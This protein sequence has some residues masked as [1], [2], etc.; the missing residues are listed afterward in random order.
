MKNDFAMRQLALNGGEPAVSFEQPHEIWPPP[1]TREELEELCKQRQTDISIKGRTGVIKELEEQYLQFLDSDV[2]YGLTF[3][4]GTSAL[5]AAYFALG[6]EEGDEVIGSVLTFHAALSPALMLKANIRL[7]DVER[8]SR[9]LDPEK[10]ESAITA[11][12]K[13]IT[14]VHQWGHP[15]D[16]DRILKIA[17]K[18][19][20]KVIEDCSH[21]HGSRFRGK[22]CGTFGD[23]AV[24]SFQA[25]K[26]IFAGEGGILVT[27]NQDIH[28]RATLLGHYRDRSKEEILNPQLQQYWVTGFGLKLR[29]SPLNAV[30]AKHALRNFSKFK[31][32][33]HRCLNFFNQALS[34]IDYIEPHHV[35]PEVDMGAW[36]G[37]K[38]LYLPEK[39]P[40]TTFKKVTEALRA[41][42]VEVS[43]ASAPLLCTQPLYSLYPDDM[44]PNRTKK[45][46]QSVDEFPVANC[47]YNNCFSLPT[48]Y[49]WD[50]DR[51]IIEQY[52]AAFHKVG[53]AFGGR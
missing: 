37:F 33:R 52:I 17:K 44:Y 20:L 7:V 15:A 24:F 51:P 39:L 43:Q 1:A 2:R 49:D 8:N 5:L 11:R 40:G 46:V 48:F 3:N 18:H 47:I 34:S 53:A 12:T 9:C 13:V 19:K 25:A 26:M 50:R 23:V 36:Y 31:A 14:V 27:N 21:A 41:E 6:I 30:V 35:E 29:M 16:M 38:P 32:G 4:S 42:G 28:E 22:L 10:L 45:I